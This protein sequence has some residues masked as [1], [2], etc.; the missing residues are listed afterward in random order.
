MRWRG[1]RRVGRI[2]G[3]YASVVGIDLREISDQ[4]RDEVLALRLAPGQDRFVGSVAGCLEE[5][6]EYPHANPWYRAVS[7]VLRSGLVFVDDIGLLPITS[8]AAEGHYRLID[9]AY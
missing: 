1:E 5:A 9:A 2:G 4:N 3:L 6:S 7:P 8:D